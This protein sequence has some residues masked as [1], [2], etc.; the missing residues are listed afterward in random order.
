MEI[1]LNKTSCHQ[2]AVGEMAGDFLKIFFDNVQFYISA[3]KSCSSSE[4]LDM[5]SGR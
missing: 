2:L 1:T 3:G 5:E 4:G